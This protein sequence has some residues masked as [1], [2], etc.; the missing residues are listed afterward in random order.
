MTTSTIDKSV[1]INQIWENNLLEL[2]KIHQSQGAVSGLQFLSKLRENATSKAKILNFPTKQDEDWRFT[3][4]SELSNIRFRPTKSATTILPENLSPFILP[5]AKESRLIFINGEY[6]PESSGL[7]ALPN[8][9]YVG[10]LMELPKSKRAKVV[11]YLGKNN[12]TEDF[13][14]LTNTAGLHHVAVVWVDPKIIVDVPI[15]LLFVSVPTDSY[16]LIQPRVLV[17]AET[18]SS[19]TLVENYTALARECSDSDIAENKSYLVNGVTEIFVEDNAH[20]NHSRIQR[21][22]GDSFHIGK[23]AIIQNQEG[24]Y[25][26]NE[27]SLGAKLSRHTLKVFQQGKQTETHLSGLTMVGSQQTLDTHSVVHL[28]FP[29]GKVHQLHKCIVDDHG[30]GVFNGKISVSK[31]A[32]LTNATQ[33]NRNLLLSPK[34]RINTKPE[35][36]IIADNVQCSHGATISQLESDELFY[37]QSRG[38]NKND[39]RNLLIDAF[40]AE[41]LEQLPLKSLRQRLTQCVACRTVES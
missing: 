37:L 18:G 6:A 23:T 2:S 31:P 10:N 38:L 41:I 7:S 22:L 27:I 9:V 26:C 1:R 4:L 33:L 17:I 14:S 30:Y 12:G 32:Q 25:I 34:A 36:H 24:R 5:E 20:V 8:G 16:S 28:N 13:F 15:H 19:I 35:L 40:A 21:E 29:Y 3:D 39:A 11:C